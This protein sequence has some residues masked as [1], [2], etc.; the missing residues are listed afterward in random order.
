LEVYYDFYRAYDKKTADEMLSQI[1]TPGIIIITE[2]NKS[3]I[4]E[5]GRLK[6]AYK[7]SLADSFALAQT[8]VSNGVLLTSDHHKFDVVAKEESIK[9][10]WIK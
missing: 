9:F 8:I 4:T 6:T 10:L 5:A 3:I 2:I 1:E 7:I